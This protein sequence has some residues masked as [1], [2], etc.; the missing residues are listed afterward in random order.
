MTHHTTALGAAILAVT[1]ISTAPAYA[2]DAI[3]TSEAAFDA[4][5]PGAATYAFDEGNT[6]SHY[7]SIPSPSTIDGFEFTDEVTPSDLAAGQGQVP[8]MFLIGAAST[9][10]YGSDFLSFQNEHTDVLGR[11]GNL[12]EAFGFDYGSYISTGG[13]ATVTLADGTSFVITPTS[14]EAFLGFTSSSPI[15]SLTIDYPGGYAFDVIGL[16]GT[17]TPAPEPAAWALMLI[18]MGGLG[19][20]LRRR[21]V[22]TALRAT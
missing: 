18:G 17:A 11:I 10:T 22:V 21:R 1:A 3:Y 6:P 15:G 9:P 20:T 5:V 13:P 7:H 4:A 14:T 2:L 19:A 16:S 12:G 8:L